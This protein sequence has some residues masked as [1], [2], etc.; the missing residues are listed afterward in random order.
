MTLGIFVALITHDLS[1][2][3]EQFA[4]LLGIKW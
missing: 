4:P 1:E 3:V 2:F